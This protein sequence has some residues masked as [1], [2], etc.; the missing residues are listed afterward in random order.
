M[1]RRTGERSSAG[2][3]G[4]RTGSNFSRPALMLSPSRHT[5]AWARRGLAGG[6]SLGW[7]MWWARP[8]DQ[9]RPTQ[10]W[11]G[12]HFNADARGCTQIGADSI[13]SL[14]R[15]LGTGGST[16]TGNRSRTVM[17]GAF[18]RV[19]QPVSACICVKILPSLLCPNRTKHDDIKGHASLRRGC[20]PSSARPI[21]R[22]AN[23]DRVTSATIR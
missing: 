12:L 8:R 9:W 3:A 1:R 6:S 15:D 4:R 2:G 17:R 16:I 5:R 21:S 13:D 7:R 14:R 22:T 18:I 11:K 19:H 10:R 20:Y 23:A